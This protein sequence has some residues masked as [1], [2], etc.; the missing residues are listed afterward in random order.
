MLIFSCKKD[1]QP[2]ENNGPDNPPAVQDSVPVPE[3]ARIPAVEQGWNIF[4]TTKANY[5]YGP[6]IIINDD[7]SID[8][9]FAAPGQEYTDGDSLFDAT[10]AKSPVQIAPDGSVAQQFTVAAD[11][12]RLLVISPT[13]GGNMSNITLKLYRWQT[14]YAT[15][16]AGTVLAQQSFEHYGDNQRLDLTNSDG[17]PAGTYL[18]VMSD[19]NDPAVGKSG[20]W[21]YAS[22]KT[23]SVIYQNGVEVEGSYQAYVQMTAHAKLYWDQ[24]AYRRSVDGGHTW[25]ADEMVLKPTAGSRDQLSVCDPGVA[26]WG[27]YYYLAYTSTDGPEGKHNNA[28]VCRSESP[29][30]PW[31][32]W[33]GSG[34]GGDPA[35][36]VEY[37]GDTT[38]FGAGEPC[39]VVKDNTI[40]FYYTWNAGGSES[41]T[42]RVATADAADADW[43]AH[44]TSH[45]TAVN[46]SQIPGSDHCDVKYREDLQVFQAIHTA[47]RMTADSYLVL[48]ESQDGIHFE[49]AGTLRDS[50]LQPFLHNCGW[51]GDAMGHID[52]AKPQ[53][54]SY[55]YGQQWATWNTFWHQLN[56]DIP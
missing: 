48:W 51:S 23:G 28:F 37:T 45:G 32:K 26:K 24:I 12:Y 41:R 2:R 34:W 6:S 15:T 53:Y 8:A 40:Y 25:T 18:W 11:F 19:P 3:Y 33:N 49:Q 38:K 36:V 27:G 22:T 35:P 7:G 47:S 4:T 17:F 5:R 31:E 54:L 56:F 29:T 55:A 44:L 30:G 16:V 20:V 21:K 42:T 10:G 52:P 1:M 39:F 14:D 43:P 50:T 9:W 13:W 46:A